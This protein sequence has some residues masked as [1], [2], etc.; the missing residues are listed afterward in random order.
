[1]IIF[2]LNDLVHQV[3]I[4]L[5]ELEPLVCIKH[6]LLSK[7]KTEREDALIKDQVQEDIVCTHEIVVGAIW[8]RLFIN[9]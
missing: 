4:V 8:V 5:Q 6:H 9:A 3:L 2:F 1:M 7:V